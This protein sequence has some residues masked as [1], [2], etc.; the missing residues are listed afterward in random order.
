M[1]RKKIFTYLKT[2]L[3]KNL[4]IAKSVKWLKWLLFLKIDN[5]LFY[6]S[7]ISYIIINNFSNLNNMG[8]ASSLWYSKEKRKVLIMSFEEFYTQSIYYI[9]TYLI[10]RN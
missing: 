10:I 6:T 1:P 5:I 4:P 7:I 3:F 9:L 2:Q 8:G